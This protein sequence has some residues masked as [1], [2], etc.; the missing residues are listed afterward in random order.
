MSNPDQSTSLTDRHTGR[1]TTEPL[2]Q[3]PDQTSTPLETTLPVD[4][5]TWMTMS[6]DRDAGHR[7]IMSL[8]GP[9][10][11][12]T[13]KGPRSTASILWCPIGLD[14]ARGTGELVV[15]STRR[16]ERTPTWAQGLSIATSVAPSGQVE[17]LADLV[18]T[19]TPMSTEVTEPMRTAL[20]AGANGAPRP[21]G[22]GLSYRRDPVRVPDDQIHEWA[23]RKMQRCGLHL[24]AITVLGRSQITLQRRRSS[25]PMASLRLTGNI[26]DQAVFDSVW[27][28]GVGKGRSYGLGMLRRAN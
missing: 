23:C 12:T 25:H 19:Y 28:H 10:P 7:M 11:R 18:A 2:T 26:T 4:A 16:P 13:D 6:S 15:R 24:E 5:S 21:P 9:L 20:K 22:Q 14:P 27:H 3:T 8:W 17:L 1:R